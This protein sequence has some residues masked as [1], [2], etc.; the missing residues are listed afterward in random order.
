MF[1]DF[2]NPS[3]KPDEGREK[4]PVPIKCKCGQVGSAIW[5]ESAQPNPKGPRP[6]LLEVSSGFYLRL[7][8]RDIGTTEIMCAV[9]ES[10][11]PV[12]EPQQ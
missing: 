9:C 5:E 12:S 10:V 4:F 6:V 3:K 1:F 7:R 2:N 11:V 8:K